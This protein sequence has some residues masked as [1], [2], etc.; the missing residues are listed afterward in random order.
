MYH[1]TLI[2]IITKLYNR[3]YSY[4]RGVSRGTTGQFPP[5]HLW[6]NLIIYELASFALATLVVHL[7]PHSGLQPSVKRKVGFDN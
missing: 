6:L 4:T 2:E 7:F 1:I 5:P 3:H